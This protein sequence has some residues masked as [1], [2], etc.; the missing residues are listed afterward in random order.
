MLRVLSCLTAGL[1]GVSLVGSPAIGLAQQ[2]GRWQTYGTENGEWRSYGGNIAS[3]KYSPLDQIDAGNFS[4]L[5]IA[6]RWRSV[7][8]MV[9]RT[10]P[11]GSE[12]WAPLDAIVESLVADTPNLYRPGHLPRAGGMAA[13]PLMIGGVVYLNT[14]LS[15]GVAVDATTGE[16]RWV[17][18]P[19]SYEEGTTPMSGTFRQRGVAY[20][21]DGEGDERIFWGTGSGYLV[22]VDAQTG[23]PCADFGPDG[24]GMVDAMVGVPRAVREDRDYLNALLYGIHSPPIVV[25]DKVIHGSQV[26]DRRITK[27]AVPG[28]VRAW[29]VRTG[30]HTWDFHTVPNSPDEFGADTWLNDSWRYSGNANVWSFLSGDNELGHVYLPTGRV[31]TCF[32]NRSSPSTS[33]PGSG[34]GTSRRC[35]TDCGT[36]TSRP[37]PTSSTL[38]ST[39]AR[40]RRWSRSA[41]RA[42]S[43]RST[44]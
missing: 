25:R 38:P 5:E 27:E 44:G 39:V 16:T 24:S 12:W 13:T 21:M 6:W 23:R 36:T 17:F 34:S 37:R 9:S 32:R 18:N 7:D 14:A 26:A 22:C 31:T 29:D 30:E 3:Q 4:D 8:A 40:S 11:D 10:M 41:S 35:T 33:R 15:Q 2:S 20:W 19:K 42:S 43:T 28:W 1:I